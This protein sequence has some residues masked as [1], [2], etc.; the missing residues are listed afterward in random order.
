[1]ADEIATSWHVDQVAKGLREYSH[2]EVVSLLRRELTEKSDLRLILDDEMPHVVRGNLVCGNPDRVYDVR[3][4]SRRLGQDT[5][6]DILLDIGGQ[7]EIVRR[8][9]HEVNQLTS[10]DWDETIKAKA[11]EWT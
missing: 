9:L 1:L 7:I 2:Y 6:R 8:T 3:F 5:G 4:T 10:T 11:S